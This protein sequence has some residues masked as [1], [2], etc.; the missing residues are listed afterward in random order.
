MVAPNVATTVPMNN[1]IITASLNVMNST[2]MS[3]ARLNA[4]MAMYLKP[5]YSPLS[6][7]QASCSCLCSARHWSIF[8]CCSSAICCCSAGVNFSLGAYLG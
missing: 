6:F 3:I 4:V 8:I 2:T 7:S 5:S 1:P